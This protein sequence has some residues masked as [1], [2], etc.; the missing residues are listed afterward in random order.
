T[1]LARRDV[2][3]SD[4][5]AYRLVHGEGDGLPSLV[6]DRYDEWLVVQLLS[7]GLDAQRDVIVAA[8]RELTG[9]RG[10]LARNDPAARQREGLPREVTLLHGDVPRTVEV[11]EHGVRYIAAP[12][13]GQKTGAFLDQRE[14]RVLV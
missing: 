4:A 2:L 14:N 6:V 1:A 10:I 5:N 12:W 9:C 7:A 8:L 13:D 11:N 3:N